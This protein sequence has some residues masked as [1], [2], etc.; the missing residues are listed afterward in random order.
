M[1]W[2]ECN[3]M[4][5]RMKFVVRLEDGERMTDLCREFGI[6][7]KTGYKIWNR[8]NDVGL[9]GLFDESKRPVT[10]PHK[11]SESI[12][13]LIINLKDKR[14]TWGA[15][16]L[17]EYLIRKHSNI[18]FPSRNTFHNILLKNDLVKRRKRKN[19]KAKGTNLR[20]VNS[21]NDLWCADFKGQFKMRNGKHC[22]PLTITDQYSRFLLACDALESTK[23]GGAFAVFESVFEEYGIPQAIRTDNGVPFCSPHAV[24]GLSR[25]SVWWLRLGIE[26]ERIRPGKPQ[27]NGC[28]ERMHLTLKQ[29]TLRDPKRNI[30]VQ[31]EIF[32]KFK[33][34]YNFERPHQGIDNETPSKLF[35]K[36]RKK[37]KKKLDEIKYENCDAVRVVRQNGKM[38]LTSNRTAHISDCLAG[39]ELGLKQIEEFVWRVQFMDIVLGHYDQKDN[40]FAKMQEI[41]KVD[42]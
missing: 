41:I 25:L 8:Y 6:S 39:Q 24:L 35:K 21:S 23:T 40:K 10:S 34:D 29:D 19:Y 28:H 38:S 7:R 36:S 9:D 11:T 3:I 20:A 1:P 4:N 13:R 32:D 15:T 22:Y 33:D 17:R 12:E 31:Q 42:M 26:L 37:Y 14:P 16:K 5:E 2:K 30:L 27:E 18:P